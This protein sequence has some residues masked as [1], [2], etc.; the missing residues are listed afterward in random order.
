L[1]TL[2]VIA[3]LLP[4]AFHLAVEPDEGRDPLTDAEEGH[5]I[6]SISHGVSI[7]STEAIKQSSSSPKTYQV[8]IIL[9]FS[10]VYGPY[11]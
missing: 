3:L 2:S 10:M 11:S 9:L 7:S 5:D 4:A 8:A 1:L 6:L